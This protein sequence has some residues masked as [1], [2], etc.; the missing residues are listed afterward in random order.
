VQHLKLT[1]AFA[2][3]VVLSAPALSAGD[4]KGSFARAV[5]GEIVEE[6]IEEAVEDAA[7]DATL[8]VAGRAV[9][10]A[11]PRARDLA[12]LGEDVVD[13]VETAMEIADV[14]SKLD[15]AADAIENINRLRRLAR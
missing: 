4:W 14:A 3:I 9:T 6:G 12:D 2:V 5:I 7:L 15:D 1:V 10:A 8:D 11:V 13:G